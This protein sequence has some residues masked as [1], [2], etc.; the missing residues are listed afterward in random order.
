MTLNTYGHVIDDALDPVAEH[1]ARGATHSSMG[2]RAVCNPTVATAQS[3][4]PTRP[5]SVAAAG[6]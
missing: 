4:S 6:A 3:T 5:R 1:D 2:W